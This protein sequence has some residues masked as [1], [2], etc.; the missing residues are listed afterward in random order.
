MMKKLHAFCSEVSWVLDDLT[1]SLPQGVA[2]G[3]QAVCKDLR[4]TA[5]SLD[6]D[7]E[8]YVTDE[9]AGLLRIAGTT[10]IHHLE[11]RANRYTPSIYSEDLRVMAVELLPGGVPLL[12]GLFN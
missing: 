7:D 5:Q 9:V 10:V 8:E 4:R 2:A 6:P 1:T 3:V 11:S 12:P